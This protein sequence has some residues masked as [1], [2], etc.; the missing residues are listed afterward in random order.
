M[1]EQVEVR[2]ELMR[3]ARLL[4]AEP[5]ELSY[6]EA[7]PAAELRQL[8]GQ[9]TDVL[10]AENPLLHRIA[11]A[12]RILPGSVAAPL[13]ERVF[14]AVLTA[15]LAG[16]VEAD[17]AVEIA[18]KLPVAFL[19]DVAVELDPRRVGETLAKI[20]PAQVAAVAKEL[21]RRRE[22]LTMGTVVGQVPDESVAAALTHADPHSLLQVALV[23]EDKED[24]PRLFALTEP[25]R[26]VGIYAA[27]EQAGL[28]EEAADLLPYLTEDQ[29]ETVLRALEEPAAQ[30]A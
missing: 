13:A 6:L 28:A 15:R 30:S 10:F 22:Y 20:P 14:G 18:G 11:A 12:A 3:L 17:K 25:E 27:A 2:A 24:L 23:L 29:R 19:A 21:L 5:E 16:V 7:V 1:S 8:R 4:G 9:V 26:I